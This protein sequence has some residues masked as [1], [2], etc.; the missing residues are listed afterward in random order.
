MKLVPGQRIRDYEI[1]GPLGGGGMGEVYLA[2]EE[3]LDR[4]VAIKVLN[5]DLTQD[6]QFVHRFRNEARIQAKL[7][8]PNIVHLITFFCEEGTHYMVLEYAPGITLKEI[9]AVTGPIQ[10]KRAIKIIRQL[11]AA[12]SQAHS[13]GIVHRDLKPSNIMVDLDNDDRVKIMDFGIA[14]LVSDVHITRTGTKMG[15]ILYMSPE[16]VLAIKDIDYRSDIYSLGV[17]MYE[18]L[19]GKA[20]YQVNT[21]SDFLLQRAIVD[22]PLPDPRQNY[23][24]I[25]DKMVDLLKQMTAK[26]RESRPSL[27]YVMGILGGGG[28]GSPSIPSPLVSPDSVPITD[29]DNNESLIPIEIQRTETLAGYFR[30]LPLILLGSTVA[31]FLL[32]HFSD[33]MNSLGV[34][35]F[36][37][38]LSALVH[39]NASNKQHFQDISFWWLWT[40]VITYLLVTAVVGWIF[41]D[42]YVEAATSLIFIAVQLAVTGL[43]YKLVYEKVRYLTAEDDNNDV[44]KKIKTIFLILVIA[45][46]LIAFGSYLYT[47]LYR[48][49]M[50]NFYES[51]QM[52]RY[53]YY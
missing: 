16:Q 14:R 27:A 39:Y 50:R 33:C 6:S 46:I 42:E 26:N 7:T 12:L 51:I 45:S 35:I 21:D 36:A 32:V 28:L 24:Y 25:S 48:I 5:P 49:E 20:A 15:T 40:S 22:T 18:M 41:V 38:L 1:V 44:K 31:T 53:P 37:S 8:H 3:M 13:I 9:I 30:V 52:R 17:V 47:E 2:N 10:E 4:Q 29:G 19:C 11:I 43:A 34:W 23:Q